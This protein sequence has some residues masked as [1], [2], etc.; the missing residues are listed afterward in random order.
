[1]NFLVRHLEGSLENANPQW[2]FPAE[3]KVITLSE[4]W[5]RA[6][7]IASDLYSRYKIKR[8]D[9]IVL[10]LENG[11]DYV[12]TLLAVWRLGAVAIPIR[13]YGGKH[14]WF[15]NYLAD[16]LLLTDFKLA[17]YEANNKLLDTSLLSSKLGRPFIPITSI[18][19]IDTPSIA[20]LPN[21]ATEDYAIIQFTSG[22]TGSPKG[23][24]VTHGMMMAQLEQL[25]ENHVYARCGIG[26][27][28]ALSWLPFYHDM[29]MFIGVLLPLYEL[30]HGGAAPAT[31]YM[32]NPGRWFNHLA[33][34][35][36]DLSFTTN[37]VLAASVQ[38]LSRLTPDKCDLSALHLYIAAEKVNARV[39]RDARR[40]LENLRMPANQIH[41][42]YGMA[43]YALGCTHSPSG[44]PKSLPIHLNDD[45]SVTIAKLDQEDTLELVSVGIPNSRCSIT[46]RDNAGNALPPDFVGEIIV[47][48]PCVS[49]G[50][51]SNPKATAAKLADGRLCTGDLG[52]LHQGE[53]YF[54]SRKDDLLVVGGRNIVPSDV[55]HLVEELE[56][57]GHGRS[58]LFGIEN[59]YTSTT[60]PVLLVESSQFATE[61]ELTSREELIRELV[62][63]E[64]GLFLNQFAFVEKGTIEKTSSGK[65]RTRVIR[66]RY[67]KH[68]IERIQ[69]NEKSVE[70]P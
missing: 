2:W 26:V 4:L 63:N 24:I 12:S 14:F 48:G 25:H 30:A 69:V 21:C 51:I 8:H 56:F 66:E 57:V 28:R 42:G 1:M 5:H 60:Y 31:Y 50:Y 70:I 47:E 46:V 40:V 59:A 36:A 18:G 65:K 38:Q 53:L 10:I 7:A 29:G 43:E 34:W 22:S 32:R 49:P 33:E 64:V 62:A 3:Q 35:K 37:S 44:F 13:P 68:E 55:E 19:H 20:A 6:G 9:K 39:L 41:I 67:L 52:F 11:S 54:L 58:V 23:V 27:E 15:E 61:S 17:I 16:L 45:G